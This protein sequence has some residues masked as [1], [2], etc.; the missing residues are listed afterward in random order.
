MRWKA[1]A[2]PSRSLWKRISRLASGYGMVQAAVRRL[3][4]AVQA[5]GPGRWRRGIGRCWDRRRGWAPE[6]VAA[7]VEQGVVAGLGGSDRGAG[8]VGGVRERRRPSSCPR[9]SRIGSRRC[10]VT[11]IEPKPC[12][13]AWWALNAGQL[14]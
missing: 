1:G 3:E 9:A 6:E 14:L 8:V 2:P 13:L 12:P 11:P 4:V 10:T 7:E 5:M